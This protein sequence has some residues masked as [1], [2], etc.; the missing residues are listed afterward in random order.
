MSVHRYANNPQSTLSGAVG[1]GDSSISVSSAT[2]FPTL[3]KFTIIVDSEIM[4]VTGV[5]GTTFTVERGAEATA[6]VSHTNNSTVTQILTVDSFLNAHHF[7]VRAYGAVG[8][9]TT[10]D[11]SA[12][13][14]AIAA[15]SDAGGGTVFVPPGTWKLG[16]AVQLL[17]GV[18]IRGAGHVATTLVGGEGTTTLKVV[19]TAPAATQI[20]SF[21]IRDMTIKN[22]STG[23]ATHAILDLQYCSERAIQIKDVI[24]HGADFGCIG[25]RLYN[26]WGISIENVA[27]RSL[28]STTYPALELRSTAGDGVS[29][30]PMNTIRIDNCTWQEFGIGIS[31]QNTAD[32]SPGPLHAL[33]INNPRFKNTTMGTSIGII[34]NSNQI[35][36]VNIIGGFFEDIARG[37]VCTGFNWHIDGAFFQHA[38]TAISFED[39]GKH[40]ADNISFSS[41]TGNEIGTGCHFKST[42]DEACELRNYHIVTGSAAFTVL[43][44]DATLLG[45]PF[46]IPPLSGAAHT[47]NAVLGAANR[48]VYVPVRITQAVLMTGVGYVVGNSAGNVSVAL[49]SQSGSRLATSGSVACPAGGRATTAFTSGVYCPPGNYYLALSASDNT[50]TFAQSEASGLTGVGL[51]RYQET[52]HPTPASATFAGITSANVVLIGRVDGSFF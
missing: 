10:D 48:A 25:M 16:T 15:A 6:A 34:G 20:N 30:H 29:G 11:A 17:Q 37:I 27:F 46:G 52:A 9:G 7:D 33:V 43:A 1:A 44:N 24:I 3:G 32:G 12:F 26:S 8:D 35:W 4:L 42:L 51:T 36:N 13:T 28:P 31:L 18:S 50:A 14:A 19:G 39:G 49:Y 2:G 40:I 21:S 38:T 45:A 22:G 47:Q 41:P 5:S 23:A